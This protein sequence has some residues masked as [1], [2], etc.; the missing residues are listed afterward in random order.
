MAT[1]LAAMLLDAGECAHVVARAALGY[2]GG[3][4]LMVP[5]RD[6]LTVVDEM[7][8]RWGFVILFVI[9]A[10]VTAVVWPL[11]LHGM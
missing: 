3:L 5:R 2:M 8:I 4:L 6:A 7:L 1:I 9:S 11:R 10:M